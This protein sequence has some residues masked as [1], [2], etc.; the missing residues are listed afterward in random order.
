MNLDNPSV[1]EGLRISKEALLLIQKLVN[2][3][4]AKLYVVLIPTQESVYAEAIEESY[5][6]LN[7]NY[8]KL[9]EMETRIRN[10]IISLFINNDIQ[11]TDTLPAL[12]KAL[13]HDGSIYPVSI[14]GHPLADGYFVIASSINASLDKLGW[15]K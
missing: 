1:V 6:T 3:A 9:V 5:G 13:L 7:P 2:E 14:D 10:E 8:T 4:D 11:Y 12:T 15:L